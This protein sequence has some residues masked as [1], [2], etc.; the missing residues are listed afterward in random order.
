MHSKDWELSS[1]CVGVL[2]ERAIKVAKGDLIV[3]E[4]PFIEVR[5]EPW[6]TCKCPRTNEQGGFPV[7]SVYVLA[8]IDKPDANMTVSK[9][10]LLL[11]AC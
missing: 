1:T 5:S 2:L 11:I 8:T 3:L 9:V 7:D 4:K 10:N 6:L